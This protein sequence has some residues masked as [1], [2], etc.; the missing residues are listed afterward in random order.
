MW[1][2]RDYN[3]EL[4]MGKKAPKS[5]SNNLEKVIVEGL[6]GTYL[7]L[8]LFL[9]SYL[10]ISQLNFNKT[11]KNLGNENLVLGT[12]PHNDMIFKKIMGLDPA[13][14]D[15]IINFQKALPPSER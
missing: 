14:R 2:L 9:F 1:C 4:I 13:I 12:N 10:S 8:S 7:S 15:L 5:G 6:D 11:N 3:D